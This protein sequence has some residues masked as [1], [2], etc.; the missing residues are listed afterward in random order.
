MPPQHRPHLPGTGRE[1]ASASRFR[2]SRLRFIS[3]H[4]DCVREK[5]GVATIGLLS[6]ARVPERE[7]AATGLEAV[8][9]CRYDSLRSHISV[10]IHD[11][12]DFHVAS[13]SFSSPCSIG[14]RPQDCNALVAIGFDG[15]LCRAEVD[16]T[17]GVGVDGCR[18]DR[19]LDIGRALPS[20]S[21]GDRD[22]SLERD[23]RPLT[24]WR[25]RC[26]IRCSQSFVAA[27]LCV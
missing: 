13:V 14:T 18:S 9:R 10:R 3:T 19:R 4:T 15:G 11:K 7:N 1:L 27:P 23:G 25:R 21:S 17:S 16:L 12:A 2:P 5:A 26:G 22:L 6:C 20:R 24:R 8:S